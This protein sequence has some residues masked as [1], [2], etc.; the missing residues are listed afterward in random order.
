M[1]GLGVRIGLGKLQAAYRAVIE[2]V[3]LFEDSSVFLLEDN[4]T[5]LLT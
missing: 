4:T 3:F 5:E 1:L 2:A